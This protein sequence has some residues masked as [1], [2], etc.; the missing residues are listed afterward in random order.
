MELRLLRSL[1]SRGE[2]TKKQFDIESKIIIQKGQILKGIRDG[3]GVT[4]KQ[5]NEF[6]RQQKILMEINRLEA[7]RIGNSEKLN[8]GLSTLAGKAGMGGLVSSAK[9][10]R[11]LW[12]TNPFLAITGIALTIFGQIFKVFLDIDNAAQE[13]RMQMGMSKGATSDVYELAKN[14]TVELR[15]VGVDA[16]T[17]NEALISLSMNLFTSQNASEVLGKNVA[18]MKS[19][20]GIATET[21]STFLKTLGMISGTSATAQVNISYFTQGLTEAAGVPL[22]EVMKDVS[23]A[24]KNSY[25]FVSKTGMSLIKAAVEAR[26]MGTSI[27]SSTKSAS[28]LL[29]FSESVKNEMEASVL[30]GKSINLQKARELAYH[31]DLKGLNQEILRIT[32]D[33]NFEQLDP[34]QQESVAKA[35]GKSA[36]ELGE[37]LV[38]EK[39]MKDIEKSKVPEVQAQLKRYKDLT[40]MSEDRAKS[41]GS[42]LALIMKNK[43]NQSELAELT[44]KWNAL[45]QKAAIKYL[46]VILDVLR[47]VNKQMDWLITKADAFKNAF[48]T[49][50]VVSGLILAIGLFS[51]LGALILK[52]G[53]AIPGGGA[54]GGI[55]GNMIGGL[56]NALNRFPWQA[57]GKLGA[58]IVLILGLGAAMYVL[59]KGFSAFSGVKWS[60]VEEGIKA[61]VVLSGIA[62]VLG[63]AIEIMIPGAVVIA[64]LGAALAIFSLGAMV[65]AKAME[66]LGKAFPVF[67]DGLMSIDKM[68]GIEIA[69]IA[70]KLGSLTAALTAMSV[71]SIP[72]MALAGAMALMSTA[73]APFFNKLKDLQTLNFD[74]TVTQFSNLTKAVNELGKAFAT[75]PTA[76]LEKLQIPTAEAAPTKTGGNAVNEPSEILTAIKDAIEGLRSDMKN[77]SLTAN[78]FL[79]SQRLDS[80]M[81]RRLAYT[82]A[83][84]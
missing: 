65:G 24:A 11:D 25:Q 55:L 23:N 19:Q 10:F 18:L 46:P 69:R 41:E 75:I 17:A 15:N 31:K 7:E 54:G 37:M 36:G 3:T 84:T 56:G 76:K 20:M 52:I 27:D 34:I 71:V 53:S 8:S 70:V 68:G 83:L 77:G 50:N 32:K 1:K 33:V 6:V 61:L 73:M 40:K 13:F 14:L 57:I 59:A 43:A 47:W 45:L 4:I 28:S 29:N 80:G 64:A 66:M 60:D 74:K 12:K 81:S 58:G 35:L 30:V 79:D 22:G 21:S 39:Q 51:A 82:G 48:S 63:I 62:A 9:E 38:A 49:V 42:N 26:R 44:N 67:V 16:K 5:G 78:V 72:L 2:I